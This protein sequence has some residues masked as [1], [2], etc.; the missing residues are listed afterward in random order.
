MEMDKIKDVV[1]TSILLLIA[2]LTMILAYVG[3]IQELIAQ[4]PEQYQLPAIIVALIVVAI[5]GAWSF[6]TS[7]KRSK[8]AYDQGLYEPVPPDADEQAEKTESDEP[9]V[10]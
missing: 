4:L 8:N 9:K 1:S 7:E 5:F 6:M 10:G 3:Q 2:I